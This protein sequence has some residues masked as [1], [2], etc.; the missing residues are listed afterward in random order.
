MA[1]VVYFAAEEEHAEAAETQGGEE[2]E[3]TVPTE[4]TGETETTETETTATTGGTDTS[5]ATETTGET[6]DAEGDPAAGEQVFAS[7]GCGGCHTL[8]AAGSSG[9]VGPNLDDAKPP[10]ELV[11]ERVT[12]GMGPMP[13]FKGQ[14][15]EQQIQDVAAFVVES[16]QG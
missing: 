8:E 12:N 11:V 15:S 6:G 14:L 3:T 4:T 5:G 2:P 13:S 1:G 16:T 9:N 10:H 7:A